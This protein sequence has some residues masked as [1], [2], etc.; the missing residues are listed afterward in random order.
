MTALP[1]S[2]EAAPRGSPRPSQRSNSNK[3]GAEHDEVVEKKPT[4]LDKVEDWAVKHASAIWAN[5]Q[6]G[7]LW[8]RMLKNTIASTIAIIIAL[9]PA[10]IA[11]YGKATYLAVITTVF[12]HPGRRFGMMAEAL[13]LTI[14]G[15][16]FGAAWSVL[17]VYLSSLVYPYNVPAAFTIKG[18]FLTLAVLFHGYLRS[19]TPR[20][21]LGVLLML[22]VV[23]V[24]LTSPST[25]VT[26]GL[27]TAILYPILTAVGIL[28]IV[29]VA[30]FPEF[31]SSFLGITT[32]ETLSQTVS[33]LRD[34]NS[35]FVAILDP[36]NE[37]IGKQGGDNPDEEAEKSDQEPEAPKESL[38]HRLFKAVKSLRSK[39]LTEEH[40]NPTKTTEEER[41]GEEPSTPEVPKP[42]VPSI[43]EL[44][45]LT[46]QK[47]KLRAKLESCKSA[48]QECM[49]ELAFAV[50]PPRDLK[51][52]SDTSMKK[53]VANTI[54]LIGACE[55]KYALLGDIDDPKVA[56]DEAKGAK[57]P[58]G[59]VSRSRRSS[60]D[61]D[62]ET[63]GESSHE[64]QFSDMEESHMPWKKKK[65][66]KAHRSKSR[67]RR[68]KSR[69]R[70]KREKEDLEM[71][72]PQKEI[73][74][75]DEEL[76]RRLLKRIEAPLNSLQ[77]NIDKSVEVITSCLAYCYDVKK[78]PSG[79]FPPKGIELEEL[80]IH[81][82][83]MK[84][85]IV[86]FDKNASAAL[87][88]ATAYYESHSAHVDVTPRMEIFL[89]S[90]FILNLRQA[91]TN[92]RKM[93]KH[94]RKL[95]EKR[96][97]RHEKRRLWTPTIHWRKWLTTGGEHDM[98]SLPEQGR[99]DKRLGNEDQQV[100]D[101]GP[102]ETRA[103]VKTGDL[104]AGGQTATATAT[105]PAQKPPTP[106][107]TKKVNPKEEEK[108]RFARLR[109][110]LA[111]FVDGVSASDDVEYAIKL[112]IAVLL[113]TW[114]AFVGKWNT[115]Y[116]LNRGL[117]AAL[118][119][120]LITEV[121]IGA[122][123]WVFL[124]RVVGT[125]IGCCWGLAAFEASG[126]NRVI[127]VVMLVIGVVP[128][129]YVQLGTTYIKAGMVCIVSM[130][131]VALAT[132][133]N[134]LSGGAVDNFLKRLIAFLIGGTVAIF[135]EFAV[136]PVR[137]RDRLVESLAAAIQKISEMEACLAYGIESGK[138]TDAR[139]PE[140]IERFEVAMGKAEDALG[141]AAAFLP[142]C[143][144]EPRLKGSFAGLSLVY[145]EVLYV[146]HR[147]IERMDN[148]LQL[149]NEYGSGV[150]EEL[151]EEIYAY[152]RNLA[153]SITLILFAVH[154]A[155]TTKLPLPQFLPSARLAHLRVVNRVREL[156]L[157]NEPAILGKDNVERSK[158]EKLMVRRMLHQKFLSWNAASA[159]QIEV[160]EYLEELV[161]LTKLLVGANEF[162]SGLLTRPSYNDYI[163]KIK[164]EERETL[165]EEEKRGRQDTEPSQSP[166]RRR[167]EQSQEAEMAD[168][169]AEKL[170]PGVRKR[171]NT[172]LGSIANIDGGEQISAKLANAELPMSLRRVRSKRIE[173][174]ELERI[175]S[176]Q[177]IEEEE[178]RLSS[179][180]LAKTLLSTFNKN[181][182][183]FSFATTFEAYLRWLEA[184]RRA[185]QT[186]INYNWK[187]VMMQWAQ[188]LKARN[189]S[190]KE[191]VL[192]V[193]HWKR[194]HGP[195]HDPKTEVNPRYPPTIEELETAY[196][197]DLRPHSARN[198]PSAPP[199]R[200]GDRHLPEEPGRG[201][202][203]PE[204]TTHDAAK[205]PAKHYSSS[206]NNSSVRSS[207]PGGTIGLFVMNVGNYSNNEVVEIFHP[208]SR[209]TVTRLESW[210]TN[211]TVH[212]RTIE[213]RD[214]AFHLLPDDLKAR[215]EKDFTRPLVRIYAG[216]RNKQWSDIDTSSRNAASPEKASRRFD[217]INDA[218]EDIGLYFMNT[219]RYSRKDV[220]KLFNV[221]DSLN[222]VG[223]E[224][225]SKSNVVVRFPSVYLRDKALNHLPS[226][227]KDDNKTSCKTS[228]F[229]VLCNPKAH[230]RHPATRL[231]E[232]Q[233]NG[234]D[235]YYNRRVDKNESRIEK[236][237][238]T[239]HGHVP[240]WRHAR[241]ENDD[242]RLPERKL[243]DDGRLS[244]YESTN[245]S[246]PEFSRHKGAS[247]DKPQIPIFSP[248]RQNEE[249][250][251][252]YLND[253]ERKIWEQ[254][255]EVFAG[256]WL[257]KLTDEIMEQ[258][259]KLENPTQYNALA[260]HS[261]GEEEP[262][263]KEVLQ[264]A[265]PL[266][267]EIG[268]ARAGLKRSRSPNPIDYGENM[269]D[270]SKRTKLDNNY[271]AGPID[272][273]EGDLSD[274][275]GLDCSGL[276]LG[277]VK[278]LNALLMWDLLDS[279]KCPEEPVES[280]TSNSSENDGMVEETLDGDSYGEDE[281]AESEDE[282]AESEDKEAE[283]GAQRSNNELEP[284]S[285]P[286][287]GWC[288]SRDYWAGSS[289]DSN[290][291]ELEEGVSGQVDQLEAVERSDSDVNSDIEIAYSSPQTPSE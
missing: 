152:R 239:T 266:V 174:R 169:V 68:S 289:G 177:S 95:V 288:S 99:K 13:I 93:L 237:V 28:L 55:S 164:A 39:P 19:H 165:I 291:S 129:T 42:V 262:V 139:S 199:L 16:L 227:L 24:T 22:I 51:P 254:G 196:K 215:K 21:F 234:P 246:S 92:M 202:R 135:I 34:A 70:L 290:S 5:M 79:A 229:V 112:T 89:I 111:D 101:K 259:R 105:A 117:W 238:A 269:D 124:L 253:E 151:N 170:E 191:L 132:V 273:F 87:E 161:D 271:Y 275:D 14:L 118:Q 103:K 137:A 116:Y 244:R 189:F 278:R 150:L 160:I 83:A 64:Q 136:L 131:I 145:Q 1:T 113:V 155:L 251:N 32:I 73:K 81:I 178:K 192:E 279:A 20:L 193:E 214:R 208:D 230:G 260:K 232:R 250:G 219:G 126:G 200:K 17:G 220:E 281:E 138:N 243:S 282:E 213:D 134:T 85:S 67:A 33:T 114:P 148:I 56:N 173:E 140:V 4:T 98:L 245:N 171:R 217:D 123:V 86:D 130:S 264:H 43:V 11:V 287:D 276:V 203:G 26:V 218:P 182:G 60:F 30:V 166:Q 47:A 142:F 66:K 280:D 6:T 206:P 48:Q 120:V 228:L 226:Y 194:T 163:K 80:D 57:T 270:C 9:I 108:S 257:E 127:T 204:P 75:A 54:S 256:L 159:G 107:V 286:D 8:Q 121:V 100:D 36:N 267:N 175:R 154:E 268:N 188:S 285:S 255:Q 50:L 15:T 201:H 94:S 119:L 187:N 265:A 236:S 141:A 222:I 106:K 233:I 27:A 37:T 231:R 183:K 197:M 58:T 274:G 102:H 52:I 23:V 25:T 225:L 3:N 261:Y 247:L 49:F 167:S 144:Q 7:N 147:I 29:N 61:Q 122:S 84:A 156:I 186:T 180:E 69:A 242:F 110:R 143:N 133:D 162:R 249:K 53:L 62:S 252:G 172:R 153:G 248:V 185:P 44:K 76:M 190:L 109:I 205:S 46:D 96:Q 146:L 209:H 149:R 71:V 82:D 18:V 45:S 211:R 74:S 90:S 216:R 104:E 272:S 210:L 31:S 181:L 263:S 125:T 223:V 97:E 12:G 157:E 128:S 184:Q 284:I 115:W 158:M 176:K 77:I 78:L 10:V 212:F 41:A 198:S 240:R 221:R 207:A 258:R 195:F 65:K 63:G 179:G 241:D 283:V 224:R 72:K 91:A 38:F 168:K 40:F 59:S 35:Y 2:P 88:S 235:K 277:R